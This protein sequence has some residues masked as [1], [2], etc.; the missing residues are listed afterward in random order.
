MSDEEC[1]HVVQT[2]ADVFTLSGSKYPRISLAPAPI[3]HQPLPSITGTM[4]EQISAFL[5]TAPRGE[6][7]AWDKFPCGII[8]LPRRQLLYK[9]L[10]TMGIEWK[11]VIGVCIILCDPSVA[12]EI[13]ERRNKRIK[14][15]VGRTGEAIANMDPV[16]RK[17]SP[18]DTALYRIHVF[19]HTVVANAIKG[20]GIA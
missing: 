17:L 9:S 16:A 11:P 8:S 1:E 5:K 19:F 15:E 18:T 7:I 2:N 4:T 12:C 6:L 3:E 10:R 14:S 20:L 13:A